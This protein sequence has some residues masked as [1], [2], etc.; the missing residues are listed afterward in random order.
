VSGETTEG[1]LARLPAALTKHVPDIVVLE[2]GGNDAL[3]GYPVERIAANVDAMVVLVERAGARAVLVGMRIPP[4]YGP[5]YANAFAALFEDIAKRHHVAFVPFPL[6]DVAADP[7][8][9]QADGIHPTAAAQGK[10]LEHV[11]AVLEPLL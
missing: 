3:R 4:N 6:I 1:G 5:R 8:M 10:I 11:L 9:M 2:L 7:D